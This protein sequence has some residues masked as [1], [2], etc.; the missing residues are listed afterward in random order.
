MTDP[1]EPAFPA[2][3]QM[4]DGPLG[5]TKREYFAAMALNGVAT[6]YPHSSADAN[7]YAQ[8][9]VDLADAIIAKLNEEPKA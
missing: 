8:M 3:D 5:L 6:Q 2:L 7:V 4:G 1:I 9:V